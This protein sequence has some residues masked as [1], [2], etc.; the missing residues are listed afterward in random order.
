[1]PIGSCI[2]ILFLI[3]VNLVNEIQRLK[4]LMVAIKLVLAPEGA[5]LEALKDLN[6]KCVTIANVTVLRLDN[7]G[8]IQLLNNDFKILFRDCQLT[9]R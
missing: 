1:M 4:A 2:Y 5:L 9:Q 3:C 8:L 7:D 6:S